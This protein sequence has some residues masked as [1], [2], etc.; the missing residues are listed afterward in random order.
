[1]EHHTCFSVKSG[2][3]SLSCPCWNTY[4]PWFRRSARP[5]HDDRGQFHS[6]SNFIT[7]PV[8]LVPEACRGTVPERVP[9]PGPRPGR[10]M[11]THDDAEASPRRCPS[12]LVLF[13]DHTI[14]RHPIALKE[15][16][17]CAGF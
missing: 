1:M 4:L 17:P 8:G 7:M 10:R 9:R 16:H 13:S 5:E 6:W 11:T 14:N 2:A 12:V 3:F 15:D